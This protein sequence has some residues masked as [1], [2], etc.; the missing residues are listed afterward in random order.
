MILMYS[1][2]VVFSVIDIGQILFLL[3]TLQPSASRL[4]P[5]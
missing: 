5:Q 3:L 4:L 2:P 1:I